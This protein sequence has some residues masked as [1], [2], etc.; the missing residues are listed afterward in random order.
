MITGV[1][2][3]QIFYT[4]MITMSVSQDMA[5]EVLQEVHANKDKIKLVSDATR[6]ENPDTYAT[7]WSSP[8]K[9][10]SFENLFENGVANV[11]K[12]NGLDVNLESYWTAIYNQNAVH[13]MHN[14]ADVIYD[15]N[16]LS[17]ILYLTSIGETDFFANSMSAKYT[18]YRQ[19]SEFGRIV[20]FPS[21]LLHSV[22]Y[23][24]SD[25]DRYIIAF[26]MGVE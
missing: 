14:H 23:H 12:E 2:V 17:G 13:S 26:N 1:N 16:L 5:Q 18:H 24:H 8:V 10:N 21:T 25:K 19:N 15:N 3:D 9:V 6:E 20:I 4:E 11:F 7:D 22:N